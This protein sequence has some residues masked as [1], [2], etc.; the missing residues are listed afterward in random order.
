MFRMVGDDGLNTHHKVTWPRAALVIG[1]TV[2]T[3]P[4]SRPGGALRI[5]TTIYRIPQVRVRTYRE[6]LSA[7][8]MV[9]INIDPGR[10]I[11]VVDP[12]I[13]SG[14]TEHMG[15]CIYGGLYDPD[16]QHGLSDPRTGFR[17]DVLKTLKELKIPIVRY[18]GG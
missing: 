2:R 12:R 4:D 11:D 10:I 6:G 3:T 7:L 17:L 9:Y 5:N 15:R 14:F 16:N 13:Y 8:S 18:P 1:Q